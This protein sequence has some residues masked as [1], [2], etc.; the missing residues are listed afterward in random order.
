MHVNA[1]LAPN[2]HI[3]LISDEQSKKQIYEGRNPLCLE[4][5][6]VLSNESP[7][8]SLR[9]DSRVSSESFL[10]NRLAGVYTKSI[11]SA[12][13]VSLS[14]ENLSLRMDLLLTKFQYA[15]ILQSSVWIWT[16]LSKSTLGR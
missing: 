7:S 10:N 15:C 1:Y 5:S 8:I 14:H 2:K 12:R 3:Y 13:G 9:I 11:Y 16:V 6:D 4:W